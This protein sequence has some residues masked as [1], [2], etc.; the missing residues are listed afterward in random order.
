MG[1]GDVGSKSDFISQGGTASTKKNPPNPTPHT[2]LTL[3]QPHPGNHS[4]T[5]KDI[6]VVLIMEKMELLHQ[7]L[8]VCLH[9]SCLI[10]C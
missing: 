6:V 8:V 7:F 3:E 9:S 1:M 4:T 2:Q 5:L 10:V